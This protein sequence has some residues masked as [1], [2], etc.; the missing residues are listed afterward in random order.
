VIRILLIDDDR[1]HSAL[2]AAYCARFD[3]VVDCAYAGE[4][5]LQRL[6]EGSH[7]VVLLDVMLPGMS[8]FDICR[9]IRVHSR[10]PIIMLTARGDVVDR[11]NGLEMGAD[12]YMPKPF[13]PRELVARINTVLRRVQPAAPSGLLDFGS[14][15]ID[16][17]SRLVFADGHSVELTSTEYELLVLLASN[18]GKDYSRDQILSEVRGI[19]AAILTR[20]VDIL[21]SRLRAK[22]GDTSRLSLIHI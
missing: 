8:G 22:L 16:T 11:V 20:S 2:L 5:G 6:A 10:I 18:P 15:R 13:E 9:E 14:L 3:M 4:E 17:A 7:S 1:R 19:D 12:D 21:V